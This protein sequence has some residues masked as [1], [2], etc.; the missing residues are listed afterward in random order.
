MN[1]VDFETILEEKIECLNAIAE[2]INTATWC[3]KLMVRGDNESLRTWT[4]FLIH[5]SNKAKELLVE[6]L[7]KSQQ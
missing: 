5:D 2:L 7:E 3:Q 6:I 4:D 1:K